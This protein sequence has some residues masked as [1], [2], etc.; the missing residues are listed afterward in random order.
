MRKSFSN[1][2]WLNRRTPLFST[3]YS[4]SSFVS[5]NQLFEFADGV[6]LQVCDGVENAS[7]D[8]SCMIHDTEII[9][10]FRYHLILKIFRRYYRKPP[11]N[12]GKYFRVYLFLS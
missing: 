2:K 6:T 7:Y 1:P 10:L 9:W 4:Y 11:P 3:V 12:N 5:E 8:I